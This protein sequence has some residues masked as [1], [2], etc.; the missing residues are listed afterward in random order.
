MV[1]MAHHGNAASRSDLEVGARALEAGIW[2]ASRNVLVNLPGIDDASFRKTMAEEAAA[3]ASRAAEKRD[4]VIG[5]L[6]GRG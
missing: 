3:L 2:G 5:A 4:E 1:E 6:A